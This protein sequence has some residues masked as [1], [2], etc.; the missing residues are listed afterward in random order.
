MPTESE[1]KTW[2]ENKAKEELINDLN[3]E[4]METKTETMATEK[5]GFFKRVGNALLTGTKKVAEVTLDTGIV[6][7]LIQTDVL[8]VTEAKIIG[9]TRKEVFNKNR[10]R[11]DTVYVKVDAK[12]DEYKARLA[13]K[14]QEL[15]ERFTKEQQTV[16]A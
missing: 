15:K 16:T 11:I 2:L 6:L 13:E 5:K 8:C 14:K 3:T 1:F 9:S 7:S 10:G 4:T 12:T